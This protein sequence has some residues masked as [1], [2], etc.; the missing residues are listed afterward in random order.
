MIGTNLVVPKR[1]MG[2]N[3][4]PAARY[5]AAEVDKGSRLAAAG[6]L[7]TLPGIAA[8][9]IARSWRRW[10]QG[11][12]PA[13]SGPLT[14]VKCAAGRAP[15]AATP[16][17]SV[18]ICT[19]NR[20]RQLRACLD[21]VSRLESAGPWE[22]VIVDNGSSDATP[23]FLA[24]YR[25]TAPVPVTVVHEQTPGQGRARNAGVSAAR[26]DILAFT[27]DDCYPAPDWLRQVQRVFADPALGYMGGRILLHDP[28]DAA[29]TIQTSTELKRFAPH[30][31][32][33][34]GSIQGAN[35]SVRRQVLDEVGAFDPLFGPGTPFIADDI[36]LV[37]RASA[38]GWSG[39]YCP[40]AVVYHHHGRR[41]HA[42]VGELR[43][44]YSRG[45][46]AYFAKFLLRRETRSRYVVEWLRSVR[47]GGLRQFA[48]ECAGAAH[49]LVRRAGAALRDRGA[50]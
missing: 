23:E 15:A 25:R 18:I 49:Y 4:T 16:E 24:G 8:G 13:A 44:R 35:M 21:Q 47:H 30:S 1:P 12:G 32:L 42:A 2:P 31:F 33:P 38:A 5:A 6:M 27:D 28:A 26:G 3:E 43:W 22:L 40:D 41:S 37:A 29:I 19:R 45:R 14:Q 50:S 7:R 9:A 20:T 46:G 17:V 11:D 36:E 10:T 39:I 48:T 34:A